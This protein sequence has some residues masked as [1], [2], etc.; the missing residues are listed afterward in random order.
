MKSLSL[1]LALSAAGLAMLLPASAGAQDQRKYRSYTA[2]RQVVYAPA[3][4]TKSSDSKT[5]YW[6]GRPMG[7][8]PDPRIRLQIQR[9][10]SGFDGGTN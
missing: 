1:A 4:N 8:D 2:E 3:W 9:D 10:V 7:T 5:V 6:G